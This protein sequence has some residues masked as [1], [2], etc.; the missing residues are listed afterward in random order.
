[1]YVVKIVNAEIWNRLKVEAKRLW[2]NHLKSLNEIVP[3]V[4]EFTE[5]ELD[6]IRAY[7]EFVKN[8]RFC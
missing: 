4:N 3:E 8:R 7:A 5:D 6:D 1:M 2:K